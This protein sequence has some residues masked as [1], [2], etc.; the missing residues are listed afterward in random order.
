MLTAMP[1]ALVLREP[2]H[3]FA[4]DRLMLV[5]HVGEDLALGIEDLEDWAAVLLLNPPWAREAAAWPAYRP[6]IA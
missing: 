6:P 1:R 4:P 3:P 5:Q 2:F